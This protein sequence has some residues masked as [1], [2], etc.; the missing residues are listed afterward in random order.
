M[1]KIYPERMSLSEVW[2][3]FEESGLMHLATLD[4][5]QPRVRTMS[6]TAH[7]GRLWAVTRTGDDKVDQIRKNPKAEFTYAVP[8]KGRTGCLRATVEAS[9]VDDPRTRSQV[10]SAIPWFE[11]YWKSSDDPNF[12]LIRLDLKKLL[13][14]HHETSSKYT[15][16]L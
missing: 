8:G 10:A 7:K 9:I 14:D 13:F 1:K 12:T 6:L 15:I 3:L 2:P 11:N 4:G 5:N 16:Q